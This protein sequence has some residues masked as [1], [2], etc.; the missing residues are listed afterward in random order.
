MSPCLPIISGGHLTGYLCLPS[1]QS[2]TKWRERIDLADGTST[3]IRLKIPGNRLYR[4]A[5]C[6]KRR[7]AKNL[8]V[9]GGG[10]YEPVL[11]CARGK[12][13]RRKGRP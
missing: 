9:L 1:V 2:L 7:P 3:T 5:C 6:R 13:C 8:V 4:T 12:G 11:R 10:W